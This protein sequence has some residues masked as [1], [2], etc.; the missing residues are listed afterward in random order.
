MRTPKKNDAAGPIVHCLLRV[1]SF[2]PC[3]VNFA[4]GVDQ[5]NHRRLVDNARTILVLALAAI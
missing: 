1:C 2:N 3:K 5:Q 4:R